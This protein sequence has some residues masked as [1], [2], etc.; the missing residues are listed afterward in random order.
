MSFVS[1]TW[2]LIVLCLLLTACG[3][4]APE[5]PTD[6]PEEPPVETTLE[7]GLPTSIIRFLPAAI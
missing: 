2:P 6:S 1:K 4:D 7:A 5:T 3:A